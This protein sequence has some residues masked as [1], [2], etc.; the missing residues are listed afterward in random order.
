MTADVSHELWNI[1]NQVVMGV[2]SDE[3]N[4]WNFDLHQ[5]INIVPTEDDFIKTVRD[6]LNWEVS[7][8]LKCEKNG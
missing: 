5:K 3:G 6:Y 4:D 2:I 8:Y 7:T 1:D